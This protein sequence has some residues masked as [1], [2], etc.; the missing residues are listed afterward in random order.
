MMNPQSFKVLEVRD[1]LIGAPRQ[2]WLASLGAA[3]VTRQWASQEAGRTFRSLVREGTVVESRTLNYVGKRVETS[4]GKANALWRATR[5]TVER[6]VR[7]YRDGARAVVS[8]LP[9]QRFAPVTAAAPKVHTVNT[10]KPRTVK[11]RKIAKTARRTRRT[12]A[13]R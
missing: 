4:L 3:E 8:R 6:S 5:S 7:I 13:K 1:A 9:I 2:V 10:R 11:A 12:Q